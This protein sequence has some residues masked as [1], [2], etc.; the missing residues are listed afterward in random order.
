MPAHRDGIDGL[1]VDVAAAEADL[2]VEAKAADEIVHAI[3][4]AQ[5]RALAA[6]GRPDEGGHGILLDDELG[7][8]HG[9]E[10]AVVERAQLNVDDRTVAVAVAIAG[11]EN[12]L[13][14]IGIL[15][16]VSIKVYGNAPS[17]SGPR[18]WQ[19]AP[20]PREPAKRPR[21]SR[22]GSGRVSWKSC[23]PA[24]PAKASAP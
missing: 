1:A 20:V 14:F 17:K 7:I 18:C 10:I 12:C 15:V 24:P 13:A 6:A 8:A 3:D 11:V 9:L 22:S 19:S 4:A 21:Q 5:D 2:A 23:R 16:S